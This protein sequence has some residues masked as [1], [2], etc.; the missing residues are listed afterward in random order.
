MHN[1]GIW[2]VIFKIY[3]KIMSNQEEKFKFLAMSQT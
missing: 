1:F 2:V 3:C